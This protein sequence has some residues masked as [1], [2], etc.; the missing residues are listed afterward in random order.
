MTSRSGRTPARTPPD[1]A[2]KVEKPQISREQ[3]TAL[4]QRVS[5]AETEIERIT[6]IIAKIDAALAMPDLFQ[7][8]PKQAAQLS[9]ARSSASE[10]LERAEETWLLASSD[11]DAVKN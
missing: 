4:R 2:A 3:K 11:F 1:A 8:D 7:R 10:A 9:K 6:G 5:E